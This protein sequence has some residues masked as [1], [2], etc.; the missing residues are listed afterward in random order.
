MKTYRLILISIFWGL[1]LT[2]YNPVFGQ[3]KSREEKLREQEE[4]SKIQEEINQQK[5]E[6]IESRR[7]EEMKRSEDDSREI[8]HEE[9]QRAMDDSRRIQE[10]MDNVRENLR[11]FRDERAEQRGAGTRPDA[12]FAFAIPG[13]AFDGVFAGDDAERSSLSFSKALKETSF[14]REYVFDVA[15]SAKTVSM[16]INGYSKDGEIRIRIKMPNGKLYS[17]VVI[18]DSGNLNWKKSFNISD[19]EN[20]DKTGDWKFEIDASKA[21]GY[22]RISLQTY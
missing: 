6:M 4:K 13:F 18:D 21:T 17:D 16:S 8:D 11:E 1:L 7:N 5:K 10:V 19:D 14:K 9:M 2:S 12:P 15:P 20:Q 3:D 22:F